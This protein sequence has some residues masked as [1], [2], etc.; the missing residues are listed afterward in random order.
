M[1]PKN[2]VKGQSPLQPRQL[3]NG[4]STVIPGARKIADPYQSR[5]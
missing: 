1:R 2:P 5:R 3:N 4:E